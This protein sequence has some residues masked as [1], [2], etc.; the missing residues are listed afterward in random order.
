MQ[1]I[2]VPAAD[3]V[4]QRNPVVFPAIRIVAKYA[5]CGSTVYIL[6]DVGWPLLAQQISAINTAPFWYAVL[7]HL[8]DAMWH[9]QLAAAC[10]A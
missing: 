7:A 4:S 5:I 6:S 3:V 9:D 8:V 10:P 1:L 2:S